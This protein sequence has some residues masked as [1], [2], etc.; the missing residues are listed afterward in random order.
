MRN[1]KK[2]RKFACI[3]NDCIIG[4]SKILSSVVLLT[5]VLLLGSCGGSKKIVYFQNIDGVNLEESKGLYE[6]KIMPKDQL[7]ITV[8][9]TDPAAAAPFNLT[10]GNSVGTK[11]QL[12]Q[13]ANLQNYLVDNNGDIEFP[14]IGK[15]HVGGL[16][17]NQCQD[18]IK[19][20][21]SGYLA[22]G[23]NPIV[24][25]R[26]ASYQVTVLGEVSKPTVIPVTS[27]KMSILEALAQAGDLTI[28]GRRDNVMLLREN[29]DGRKEAHRIDLRDAKLIN[30]PYYY[31]QQN[32]V[33]YV[34]PN[35]AK[36]SNSKTSAATGIWLSVVSSVLSLTS[37][38]VNLVR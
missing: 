15:V 13:G 14:V 1:Q 21:I 6:A 8:V 17:K 26:M 18:L 2:E 29:S 30:S 27:E 32:D 19:S 38:I 11:G 37:L 16:N 3:L 22:A 28:Y 31:L 7:S 36:A 35:K 24:T 34:E 33:I 25:V 9:T 10:V 23:E 5:F 12:A 4:M 20:K